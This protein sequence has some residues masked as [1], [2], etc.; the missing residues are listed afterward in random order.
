MPKKEKAQGAGRAYH[1]G[2]DLGSGVKEGIPEEAKREG[3]KGGIRALK[4]ACAKILRQQED[5]T[6]EEV[7]E[8]RRG[9][10]TQ[11]NERGGK[12]H[13]RGDMKPGGTGQKTTKHLPHQCPL[14]H[15]TAPPLGCMIPPSLAGLPG[16]WNLVLSTWVL[17]GFNHIQFLTLPKT[18]FYCE[19]TPRVWCSDDRGELITGRAEAFSTTVSSQTI[20][21]C[22]PVITIR[23][24]HWGAVN[25]APSFPRVH[26][27]PA[28]LFL[29]F[30][31]KQD[32]NTT[33]QE[34]SKHRMLFFN[35]MRG[36]QH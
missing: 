8:S 9:W 23:G 17:P 12:Q 5:C 28:T 10:S 18:V 11:S 32:Q 6:L 33:Y 36:I 13:W 22:F 14:P 4:E 29:W 7:K 21:K 3:R 26:N 35:A 34:D 20:N 2:Y 24:P 30:A 25:C 15:W 27:A 31:G 19:L 16:L 1:R